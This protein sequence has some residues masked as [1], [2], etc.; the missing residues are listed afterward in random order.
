MAKQELVMVRHK[1]NHALTRQMTVLSAKS[2]SRNWEVVDAP[3]E[4]E[5]AKKKDVKA[6]AEGKQALPEAANSFVNEAHDDLG[7]GAE[8]AK[9]SA[10]KPAKEKKAKKI[11][12]ETD[13]AA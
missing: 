3:K 2:N 8:F 13:E 7:G 12:E 5:P 1:K 10:E 4:E 9:I 11:K 6:V